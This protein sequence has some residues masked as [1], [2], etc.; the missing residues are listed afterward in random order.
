MS[1]KSDRTL[2]VVSGWLAVELVMKCI[3]IG[4]WQAVQIVVKRMWK[5]HRRKPKSSGQVE[6]SVDSS[7]G[8]HCYIKVMV[9]HVILYLP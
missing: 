8:T 5:G 2:K 7:I 4:L 1:A 6:L 9:S 3:F